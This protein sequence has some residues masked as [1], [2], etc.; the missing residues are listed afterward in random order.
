MALVA[1]G[2][3]ALL[4][5]LLTWRSPRHASAAQACAAELGHVYEA[6]AARKVC[7][8]CLPDPLCNY[9]LRWL[10]T[11]VIDNRQPGGHNSV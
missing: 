5:A 1:A 10:A 2:A 4:G 8:C 7:K 11:V 6:V 3:R 9:F